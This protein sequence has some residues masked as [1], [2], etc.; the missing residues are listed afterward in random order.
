MKD[1]INTNDIIRFWNKVC[2]GCNK[3]D[4]SKGCWLWTAGCTNLG[5]GAFSVVVAKRYKQIMAHRY[6]LLLAT[7][8][9]PTENA[10][11]KCNIRRCV[12]VDPYHVYEGSQRD[13]IRDFRFTYRNLV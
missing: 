5:Y 10:N 3:H 1:V 2:K 12:R 4:H 8:S 13:N 7:G 6:A 9:L 11:H